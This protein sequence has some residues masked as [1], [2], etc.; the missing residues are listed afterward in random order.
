LRH[1]DAASCRR[2]RRGTSRVFLEEADLHPH[3][4]RYWL[5]PKIE[6]PVQHAEQVAKICDV[7]AQAAELEMQG[8]HVVCCD[9]K[10]GIQALER[11]APTLPTR[12][13]K[14]ERREYEYIRHG[15]LCLMANLQVAT[16]K[17]VAP[18]IGP[19]RSEEDFALHIEQT[20]ATDPRAGWLFVVDNLT[21]HCSETLVRWVAK[22]EGFEGDLGKK[23]SSGILKNVETRRAFLVD[24]SHRVRFVYTPKHCS[25]LNQIECWFSILVRRAL[26]RGSFS[27]TEAL[28]ERIR[29]FI[30]YFNRCSSFS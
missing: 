25:W 15:T 21:T 17:V 11:A 27:S 10:T 14:D 20:V 22:L 2:S 28:E 16:G 3:R 6:D 9:E 8:T 23:G 26:R 19:T 1:S 5:N 30:D 13:G 29:K 12:P 4:S 24:A 7:Y 18:S